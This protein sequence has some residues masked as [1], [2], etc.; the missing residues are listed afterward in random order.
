MIDIERTLVTRLEELPDFRK[1]SREAEAEWWE[2]HD[3]AE[4]LL[5]GGPEVRAEVYRALGIP[6]P[7]KR[8]SK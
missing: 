1:M 7:A 2:T 5:K 8:R 3:I 4:T 6:D